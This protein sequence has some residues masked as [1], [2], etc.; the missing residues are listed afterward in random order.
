MEA[1]SSFPNELLLDDPNRG[2]RLVREFYEQYHQKTDY[3]ALGRQHR[4]LKA[5]FYRQKLNA[6]GH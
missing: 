1:E 5:D 2:T 4:E 6:Q 3:T